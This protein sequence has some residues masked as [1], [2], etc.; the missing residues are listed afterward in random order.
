METTFNCDLCGT[1]HPITE[2]NEMDGLLICTDC[3]ME[4]TEVLPALRH[5]YL[6]WR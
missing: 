2:E 3:M 5:T 1:Q 4:E 6:A